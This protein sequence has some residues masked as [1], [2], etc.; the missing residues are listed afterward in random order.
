MKKTLFV[1]LIVALSQAASAQITGGLK[2]GLNITNFSGG[3][4]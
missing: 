1:A 2:A 4:F 3:R